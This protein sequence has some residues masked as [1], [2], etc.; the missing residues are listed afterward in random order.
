MAREDLL[1]IR[2]QGRFG[3]DVGRQWL[4]V[5][6]HRLGGVL[7][8]LERLGEHDGDRFADEP[9]P[10]VGQRGPG[11]VGMHRGEAMVRSDAEFGSGQDLDDARHGER[12]L[13][14]D[15]RDRPVGD[16]RAHEDRMELAGQREIG[17]VRPTPGEQSGI[18]GPKDAGPEDRSGPGR[19]GVGHLAE[20]TARARPARQAPATELRPRSGPAVRRSS[21]TSAS[22]T[23]TSEFLVFGVV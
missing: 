4:D 10:P 14:V 9:H 12:V 3:I 8:L 15:R 7:A 1:G 6:P 21:M 5:G 2:G 22:T 16:V 19:S 20:P 23:S 11:E 18:L 17:Q 13:A